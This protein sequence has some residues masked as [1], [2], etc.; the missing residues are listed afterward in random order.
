MIQ[1]LPHLTLHAIFITC[2]LEAVWMCDMSAIPLGI[3]HIQHLINCVSL[4]VRQAKWNHIKWIMW[5]AGCL[6]V[7][8]KLGVYARFKRQSPTLYW[9][10]AWTIW[11]VRCL[12]RGTFF[13]ASQNLWI[14]WVAGILVQA[15]E[16]WWCLPFV[17]LSF[18]WV[19]FLVFFFRHLNCL[20]N[21]RSEGEC[22]GYY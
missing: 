13:K 7:C 15:C 8:H 9:Y 16:T 1:L 2:S 3:M 21:T 17:T 4:G 12:N 10:F 5:C 19:F 11:E 20:S 14:G 18:L 6:Q 22:R